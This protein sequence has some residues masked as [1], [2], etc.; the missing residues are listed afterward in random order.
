[1]SQVTI[2]QG[3]EPAFELTPAGLA[4]LAEPSRRTGFASAIP[5][6]KSRG[7]KTAVIPLLAETTALLKEIRI[8]QER[9][10]D[11]LAAVAEKKDR[12][13]PPRPLT[14]LSNTRGKPWSENGLE[15]QVIDT[16]AKAGVEKHL[17]DAR[18]TFAT[19]LRKAGLSASEIADVLA[20]T[21]ERVERLLAVYVD[22]NDV[23]RSIAERIRQNEA[24]TKTPN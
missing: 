2:H 6:G 9:R 19:R 1:M 18:G 8:Q 21:E 20:W 16:K 14:V 12:P 22:M 15:H 17:H 10:H 23:V 13:A 3:T 7:R 11:I 24:G 5:A 4:Y